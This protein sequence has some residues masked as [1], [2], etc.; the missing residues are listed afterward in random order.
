M[1]IGRTGQE[2]AAAPAVNAAPDAAMARATAPAFMQ[3]LRCFFI[4]SSRLVGWPMTHS[5]EAP[6]HTE[7]FDA[8]YMPNQF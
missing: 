1:V 6:G 7:T 4:P 2:G 3:D 5:P 8:T